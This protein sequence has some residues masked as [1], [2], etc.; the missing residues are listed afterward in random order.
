ME[1]DNVKTGRKAWA[2]PEARRL[3][4]GSAEQ[5]SASG[6]DGSGFS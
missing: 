2:K 5:T 6:A 3:A 4:S 1:R